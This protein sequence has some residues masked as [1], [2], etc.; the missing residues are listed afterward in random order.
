M[1]DILGLAKCSALLSEVVQR[2]S[3][4]P[5]MDHPTDRSSHGHV[6][7]CAPSNLRPEADEWTPPTRPQN[8]NNRFPKSSHHDGITIDPASAIN[9]FAFT[10]LGTDPP[11]YI[12]T[13]YTASKDVIPDGKAFISSLAA[14]RDPNSSTAPLKPIGPPN[15]RSSPPPGLSLPPTQQ[16][17][18]FHLNVSLLPH[19]FS[20]HLLS[21]LHMRFQHVATA[22]EMLDSSFANEIMRSSSPPPSS[23]W[24][25]WMSASG[26]AGMSRALLE[27]QKSLD[28]LCGAT[29]RAG[30]VVD[31]WG[32]YQDGKLDS[33]SHQP[34]QSP[35]LG[36]AAINGVEIGTEGEIK[37]GAQAPIGRPI[38][39][40]QAKSMGS[41]LGR[42]GTLDGT[43]RPKTPIVSDGKV[44]PAMPAVRPPPGLA[45]PLAR[46][47]NHSQ[48][49]PKIVQANGA[50]DKGVNPAT[51]PPGNKDEN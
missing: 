3:T 46:P 8:G 37:K 23:R 20:V 18:S 7:Q 30:W 26:T 33:A 39:R 19:T 22:L 5:S 12:S 13:K 35:S 40:D 42:V 10:L 6:S 27:L 16:T 29:A 34:G 49:A 28:E 44:V 45:F 24:E 2:Q 38:S 50:A 41:Q 14:K 15:K 31:T 9:D 25:T 43:S 1:R 4:K 11:S 48:L 47:S 51:K 32:A 36:S 21:T 17:H